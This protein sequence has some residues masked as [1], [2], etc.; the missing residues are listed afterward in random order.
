M[1]YVL[2]FYNNERLRRIHT[3]LQ[4]IKTNLIKPEKFT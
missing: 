2:R 1:L 4:P 3:K